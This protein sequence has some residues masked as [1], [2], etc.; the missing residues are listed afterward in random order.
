MPIAFGV[1]GRFFEG[2][3]AMMLAGVTKLAPADVMLTFAILFFAV[4]IDA[5]LFEP[6]VRAIVR[7][8]H[9]DPI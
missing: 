9:G 1:A 6:F 3:G 8:V 7:F 4:M 2:L 5:G